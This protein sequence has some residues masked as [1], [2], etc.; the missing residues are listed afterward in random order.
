MTYQYEYEALTISLT[1]AGKKFERLV[2]DFTLSSKRNSPIK[3]LVF[4]VGNVKTP[5]QGGLYTGSIKKDDEVVLTW[6]LENAT[7]IAFKGKV[8][9]FFN[10]KTVKVVAKDDGIKLFENISVTNTRNETTSEIVKRL[11]TDAGLNPSKITKNYDVKF[12]HFNCFGLS[13]QE[14]LMELKQSLKV[15]YGKDVSDLFW[16]VDSNKGEFHFGAYNDTINGRNKCEKDLVIDHKKNLI[17]LEAPT[18]DEEIGRLKTHAWPFFDH[19][20]NIKVLDK[21]LA[22]LD[23]AVTFRIDEIKHIQKSRKART[24]IFMRNV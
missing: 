3:M 24:E 13:I 4:E 7:H 15:S 11:A 10:T 20:M 16:W 21:R 14:A 6:G 22:Q 17:E 8:T 18:V 1:V 5:A 2:P 19:S 23:P 12:E 9:N